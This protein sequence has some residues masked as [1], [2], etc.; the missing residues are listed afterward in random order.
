MTA[1]PSPHLSVIIAARNEAVW[2]PRA[3]EALLAQQVDARVQVIVAANA[4]SDDTAG[5]ARAYAGR[6]RARGWQLEVLE[7]GPVGK[8]GALNAAEAVAASGLRV[9]LDA[10]VVCDPG[11]IGQ[12]LA[13]LDTPLPRYATGRLVIAPTR[14]R[15][16]GA[17]ARIW[18]RLPFF[19]SGAV[20][21]GFFAINAAGRA[22]WGDWPCIVSDDTFARLHFAPEERIELPARY[23]WP[24]AE[25][26]SNLV[27]VRQRQDAGVR[28]VARLYPGLMANEGKPRLR[29]GDVLG[30]ARTAPFGLGVYG[31]VQL[32][33]RLWPAGGEWV[34][35]RGDG[36]EIGA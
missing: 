27:R 3:L 1:S 26:F 34:Q 29:A 33:A 5:V 22:R 8:L 2:L 7:L 17:Y 13:A 14:T 30:L 18:S 11:L 19:T 25:G 24:M 31:A 12:V 10:D 21:A 36:P 20:G 28:E 9:Y 6:I 35:G 23:S 15:V 16:S 32:A 4:C